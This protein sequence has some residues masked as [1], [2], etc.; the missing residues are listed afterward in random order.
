MDAGDPNKRGVFFGIPGNRALPSPS[1]TANLAGIW[2]GTGQ[3]REPLL[4]GVFFMLLLCPEGGSDDE[5]RI[6]C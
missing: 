3:G 4:A 2:K 6:F 1:P 5:E